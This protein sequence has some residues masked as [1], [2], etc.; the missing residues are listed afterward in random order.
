[1]KVYRPAAKAPKAPP[2]STVRDR[3]IDICQ[4]RGNDPPRY[5]FDMPEV[6]RVFGGGLVRGARILVGGAPGIGKSTL[7]MMIAGA[8]ARKN[9]PTKRRC[10]VVYVSGEEPDQRI[11][12]RARRLDQSVPGLRVLTTNKIQEVEATLA[13]QQPYMV[14]IDSV[15]TLSGEEDGGGEGTVKQVSAVVRR[16]GERCDAMGTTMLLISHVTKDGLLAGPRKLEHLVDAVAMF[17]GDRKTPI[18]VLQ[19]I[20]NRDGPPGEA[21][22]LEMTSD[23]LREVKDPTA[24]LLSERAAD[25]PGCVV[26]PMAESDRPTFAI[27]EAMVSASPEAF[28]SGSDEKPEVAERPPRVTSAAGLQAARIPR[29]LTLLAD[30]VTLTNRTL[31][32]EATSVVGS[33]VVEPAADLAVAAA[34]VSSALGRVFP[35]DC[36]VLGTVGVTGRTK[37]V[38]RCLGR[39][40]AAMTAGFTRALVPADNV[41]RGDIPKGIHAIPIAHVRELAPWLMAQS[42]ASEHTNAHVTTPATI[43]VQPTAAAEGLSEGSM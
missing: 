34:I 17:D 27:L 42:R 1:M 8:V 6:E 43:A 39:L 29:L 9:P 4:I 33:S 22:V 21:A 40:E 7:F 41:Q 16:I 32:V 31:D 11:G 15:S 24:Q 30:T 23:G 28:G 37:P 12:A 36:A 19:I 25:E 2:A 18:R 10:S 5:Y 3:S 26:F 35:A 13:A 14:I 38:H 20:K